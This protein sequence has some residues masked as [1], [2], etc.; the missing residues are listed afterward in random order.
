MSEVN[1]LMAAGMVIW[2]GIGAFTAFL[3][4]QQKDINRRLRELE[5]DHH[6]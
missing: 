3:A 2:I 4:W 1:W 5:R 6:A